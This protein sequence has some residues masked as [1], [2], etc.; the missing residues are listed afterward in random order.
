MQMTMVAS[1][2]LIGAVGPAVLKAV[3]LNTLT[4]SVCTSSLLPKCYNV[5]FCLTA[6][7]LG[8]T[9]LVLKLGQ[10]TCNLPHH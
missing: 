6:L 7:L 10:H 2:S 9:F 3:K 1:R 4:L 5:S 8:H